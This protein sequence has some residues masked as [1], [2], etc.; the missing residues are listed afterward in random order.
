MKDLTQKTTRKK[1]YRKIL[2]RLQDQSIFSHRENKQLYWSRKSGK[3]LE[4]NRNN[5]STRKNTQI[6]NDFVSSTAKKRSTTT[7]NE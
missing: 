5:I 7:E 4:R 2:D 3:N 6:H 1:I